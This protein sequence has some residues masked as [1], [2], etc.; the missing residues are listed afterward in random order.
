MY[1]WVF[2]QP[3]THLL[4]HMDNESS[5]LLS[6]QPHCPPQ[7]ISKYFDATL[8]MEREDLS[9]KLLPILIQY[10]FMAVKV[11]M[12]IYWQALRLFVKRTPFHSHPEC[13]S[14]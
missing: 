11:M 7:S 14:K 8:L 10:P 13:E 2:D 5:P 6:N 1:R 12:G 3:A 9:N 4:V